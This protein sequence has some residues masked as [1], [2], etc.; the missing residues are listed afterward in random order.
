[1]SA[2]T[3]A[4]TANTAAVTAL[5]AAVAA[6]DIATPTDLSNLGANT[7]AIDAA[8]TALGGTPGAPPAG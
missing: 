2:I 7:T 1:M 3:D 8:V 6:I 4:I 5:T